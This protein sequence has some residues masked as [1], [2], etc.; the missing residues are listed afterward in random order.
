MLSMTQK[1]INTLVAC[2]A[3]LFLLVGSSVAQAGVVVT[4]GMP[5]PFIAPGD[6][7][8]L[9][10]EGTDP[11][12]N[13]TLQNLSPDEQAVYIFASS[14]LGGH[15][16]DVGDDAGTPAADKSQTPSTIVPNIDADDADGGCAAAPVSGLTALGSLLLLGRRRRR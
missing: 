1:N 15:Y 14:V 16:V 8:E 13:T 11:G 2:C 5:T 9:D 6:C 3:A 10:G 4:D 12:D 7:D